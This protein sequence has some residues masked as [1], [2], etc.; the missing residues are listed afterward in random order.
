MGTS[1]GIP[2][3]SVVRVSILLLGFAFT[4]FAQKDT[5]AIVGTVL[6]ASGAAIPN[7]HV[8]AVNTATDYTYNATTDT[9]GDYVISPVRTGSYRVTVNSQGFRSEAESI[10]IEVQQR[11]RINFRLQPGDVKE[12][13]EV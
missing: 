12:T 5:G 4:A 10:T 11:A 9:T 8:T 6:D 7:A 3:R 1:S 13:V 2:N